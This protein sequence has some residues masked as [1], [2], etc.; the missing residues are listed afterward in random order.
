[1]IRISPNNLEKRVRQLILVHTPGHGSNRLLFSQEHLNTP[2]SKQWALGMDEADSCDF[3]LLGECF[4]PCPAVLPLLTQPQPN[5]DLDHPNE[6]RVQGD[7]TALR[8]CMVFKQ[9]QSVTLP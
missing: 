6:T 3:V 5:P 8:C 7:F 1:M 9:P 2:Y 4:L